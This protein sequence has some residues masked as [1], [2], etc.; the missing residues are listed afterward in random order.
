[1]IYRRVL[2]K[3]SGESLLGKRKYGIDPKA[4]KDLAKELKEVS[5]TGLELAIVIGGGNIFRGNAAAKNGL[6]R[7]TGDYM[8]M[9]ATVMN[10]LAL[11]DALE[12]AGV[13]TRVQTAIPIP[14]IAEPYIRRRALRHLEKGRIVILAAGTG[15]PYFSTDSN[16]ALR[17]LELDC[18]VIL[19]ASHVDGVYDKDPK[20]DQTAVRY[21]SLTI[22]E[23]LE[24]NLK[25]MDASA[26]ALA[27]DNKMPLVVFDFGVY[28]NIQKVINGEEIGT[29]IIPR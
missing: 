7:T 12:K 28:G 17:A 15:H 13:T 25:V 8:G 5:Q 9:L 6:D 24:K 18:E 21:Q 22:Q 19:K 16:A 20:V 14:S 29:K 3:L 26:L 2:L 1:M 23:A 11:Q 4:A 27:R 10:A